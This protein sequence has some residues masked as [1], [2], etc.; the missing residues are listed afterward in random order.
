[1]K[2]F[3]PILAIVIFIN[4]LFTGC[5][6]TTH[7]KQIEINGCSYTYYHIDTWIDCK[8]GFIHNDYCTNLKHTTNL[9]KEEK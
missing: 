7:Q 6:E 3:L 5:G 4:L 9:N 1:M 8:K 2:L